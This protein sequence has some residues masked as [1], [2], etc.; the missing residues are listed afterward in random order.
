MSLRRVRHASRVL[1]GAIGLF[2]E[3]HEVARAAARNPRR[4]KLVEKDA[5]PRSPAT[6]CY[7]ASTFY[8][9]FLG[10]D[11]KALSYSEAPHTE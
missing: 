5:T 3:D 2:L 7:V 4:T 6:N 11:L 8:Q 10:Y 1:P 9:A